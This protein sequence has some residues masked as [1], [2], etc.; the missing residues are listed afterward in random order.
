M[1]YE[2]NDKATVITGGASGIGLA[3]A[4][5]LATSGAKVVIWDLNAESLAKAQAGLSEAGVDVATRVVDVTDSDAVNQGVE[6]VLQQWDRLDVMVS[7][8]G[9]S[10]P[11]LKA[12][13]YT[14][15]DWH[16]IISINMDGVFYCQR[17]ALRAMLKSGG[18][19]IINMA[20]ILS[21][22]GFEKA[23][24]YVAAKHAVVGM[25]KAAAL[26]YATD[27]IRINAIGPGFV[28]TPLIEDS[29]DA[30]TMASLKGKHAM[31]RLGKPMEVAQLV[32]WLASDAASFVTG[33]YYPIDGGY[34]AF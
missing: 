17:A 6:A 24:G 12:A 26:E 4:R 13:E 9:I 19:S 22:V 28:S 34:L 3:C 29:L 8:A 16:K 7:N 31:Q 5:V 25:T 11:N 21:Q 10:A 15:D 30:A 33:S 20:S 2:L 18:G 23:L 14:D 1:N 27:Q 32:A